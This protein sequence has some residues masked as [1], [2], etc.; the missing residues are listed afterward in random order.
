M[1]ESSHE[2]RTA[3]A[4]AAVPHDLDAFTGERIPLT[5]VERV[6][7]TSLDDKAFDA[8]AIDTGPAHRPQ[9]DVFPPLASSTT[10]HGF[11][12]DGP[13]AEHGFSAL[14]EVERAGGQIHRILFDTGVTPDGMVENMRRLGIDPRDI[15]IVVCSHGHFDH[16]AGLDG[17][18]RRVGRANLPVMIHPNFWSRRRT[19]IP[20]RDPI[21]MP[22]TSRRALVDV[23]FEIIERQ[24]PSFLFHDSVLITGEVPRTTDFEHGMPGEEA[25]R[26]DGT[27]EVDQLILEDQAL[28]V[29]VRGRGLVAL[30]GCG[31]AGIVN[32]TRYVRQLAGVE[33]VH[34]VMGG[35][36]LGGPAF[37]S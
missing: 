30:T 6:S 24:Q 1:C 33:K 9:G 32:I 15:E 4:P 20:G 21:E 28:V 12:V 31:H 25:L 29:H 22:T 18:A 34:A 23:G 5:P 13:Q 10:E 16:T 19:V 11:V 35:F 2:T 17:L 36:H 37:D 8:L 26:G 3:H 14:V 7:I 27:W